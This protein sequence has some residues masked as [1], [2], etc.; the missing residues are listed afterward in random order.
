MTKVVFNEKWRVLSNGSG[1]GV[2][3]YG[4]YLPRKVTNVIIS[5]DLN[6][7]YQHWAEMKASMLLSPYKEK[8]I[9]SYTLQAQFPW[10]NKTRHTVLSWKANSPSEYLNATQINVRNNLAGTLKNVE[11]IVYYI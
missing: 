4:N 10:E 2:P 3:I 6:A 8:S 11:I 7:W 9:G 1:F 5:G